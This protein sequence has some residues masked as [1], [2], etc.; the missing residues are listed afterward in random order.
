MRKIKRFSFLN[1]FGK[2]KTGKFLSL[3]RKTLKELQ[4][5]A[6]PERKNYNDPW[7]KINQLALDCL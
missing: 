7:N 1:S 4:H 6:L 3:N 5:S 2:N